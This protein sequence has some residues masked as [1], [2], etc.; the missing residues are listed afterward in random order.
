MT[1]P[2]RVGPRSVGRV[3]LRSDGLGRV[4]LAVA[5]AV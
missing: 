1:E 2:G 3:S 5:A 4:G